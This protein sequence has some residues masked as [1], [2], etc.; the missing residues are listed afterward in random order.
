MILAPTV[1]FV[2]FGVLY[3]V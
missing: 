3:I 2:N 1:N